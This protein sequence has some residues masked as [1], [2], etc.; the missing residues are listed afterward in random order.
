MTLQTPDVEWAMKA[1]R[2][3]VE[4]ATSHVG[5]GDDDEGR[6][7]YLELIASGETLARASQMSAESG[8]GLVIRGLWRAYGCVD[9]RLEPPYR[10][11]RVISDLVAMAREAG[12]WRMGGLDQLAA[13]DMVLL[14][15][16][17]HV[18]TVV[19]VAVGAIH[20][21]D[22]GQLDADGH[23]MIASRER[24]LVVGPVGATLGG[25]QV[26][27]WASWPLVAWHFLGRREE[28]G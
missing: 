15:G 27:G 6:F 25:R 19:Y 23:Q 16:R 2:E 14:G 3:L 26:M 1:R 18:L 5:S 22:G 7:D 21:I 11:G 20:S 4:L 9:K 24:K 12:A 17:E 10:D 13:G 28:L 8:C